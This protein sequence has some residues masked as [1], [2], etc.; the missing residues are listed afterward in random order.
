M[1]Q[2]IWTAICN[3]KIQVQ[4][5]DRT[6]FGIPQTL[7]IYKCFYVQAIGPP[8]RIPITNPCGEIVTDILTNL[9]Q[10]VVS[11][12]NP[13]APWVICFWNYRHNLDIGSQCCQHFRGKAISIGGPNLSGNCLE[14]PKKAI[15]FDYTPKEEI[16]NSGTLSRLHWRASSPSTRLLPYTSS[17]H[18]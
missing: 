12:E 15:Q 2:Q 14:P 17:L 4:N 5:P 10:K 18:P 13:T 9:M 11:S 6:F 7:K 8:A 16:H 3:I 1:H